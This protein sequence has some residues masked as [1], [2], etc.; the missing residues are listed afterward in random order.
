MSIIDTIEA[1]DLPTNSFIRAAMQFNTEAKKGKINPS[2]IFNILVGEAI[3]PMEDP[4]HLRIQTG[5]IIQEAVRLH[6]QK[7]EI[8]VDDLAA[9]ATGRAEAF[10]SKYPET[11]A[12]V[13][14]EVKLD[15]QGRPKPKKGTKGDRAYEVYCDL[16]KKEATRKEIIE[17]FQDEKVMGMTPFSKAG[18]TTYF[19][20]MK[21][22]YEKE[23]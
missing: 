21:K 9:F 1:L 12:K 19:Y 23:V 18:A 16:M 14:K 8:N 7:K 13:E 4:D 10:I 5:Y 17:A 15:E 3:A 20:N 22:K 6:M 2:W 11:F